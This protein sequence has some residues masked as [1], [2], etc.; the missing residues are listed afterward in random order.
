M[1]CL[2]ARVAIEHGL[3]LLHDDSG[4]ENMAGVILELELA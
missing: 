3:I 1:D 4:F 2:I